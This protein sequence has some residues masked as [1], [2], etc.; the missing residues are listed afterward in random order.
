MVKD[1]RRSLDDK[2]AEGET[3]EEAIAELGEASDI[4]QEYEDLGM[5]KRTKEWALAVIWILI[6][7]VVYNVYPSIISKTPRQIPTRIQ[8]IIHT[9]S[10]VCCRIPISLYSSVSAEASPSSSNT[11]S[12]VMPESNLS[13]I[14]RLISFTNC[15]R[16]PN[17][18]CSK[19]NILIRYMFFLK[20]SYHSFYLR[21]AT[22]LFFQ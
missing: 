13:S 7:I 8:S 3:I 20:A 18:A 21:P 5:R 16:C 14:D 9:Y 12:I 4:I 2:L 22:P 17:G 19:I 15:I 1:L 10:F 11:S 6:G